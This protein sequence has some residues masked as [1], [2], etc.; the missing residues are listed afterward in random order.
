MDPHQVIQDI[1]ILVSIAIAIKGF[2]PKSVTEDMALLKQRLDY[3]ED[4][5]DANAKTNREGQKSLSDK[6][7][8]TLDYLLNQK[9]K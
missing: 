2:F 8:K 6:Q 5:V 7:D 4:K 3:I 1:S 9:D